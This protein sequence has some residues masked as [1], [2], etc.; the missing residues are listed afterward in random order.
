M[1]CH[2]AEKIILRTWDH[3]LSDSERQALSQHLQRCATCRTMRNEYHNLQQTLR[4]EEF[5]APQPYFWERLQPRLQQRPRFSI[6]AMWKRWSLRAIPAA[7]GVILVVLLAAALAF[8]PQ[9][10]ELSQSGIL[11]RNQNPFEES[12]LLSEEDLENP[13]MV[14]IFSALDER[15]SLRR[16]FP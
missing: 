5:P 4:S 15:N 1:R 16:Y 2:K 6:G 9:P 14:L 7:L 10:E 13:N 3:P 8:S 11:L 12:P